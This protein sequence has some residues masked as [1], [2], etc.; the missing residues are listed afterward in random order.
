MDICQERLRLLRD[1]F[2]F[3]FGIVDISLKS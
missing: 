2:F 1:I 3:L